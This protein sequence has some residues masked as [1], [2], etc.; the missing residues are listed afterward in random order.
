[1]IDLISRKL[2]TLASTNAASALL[3]TVSKAPNLAQMGAVGD[4]AHPVDDQAAFQSALDVIAN[5]L[6]AAPTG[7]ND[8][9]M[10]QTGA[11]L[12]P[13]IYDAGGLTQNGGSVRLVARVPGTVIIRIPADQ[14]FM[15]VSGKVNAIQV[16][17][18]TFLG[19]KG[20]F[21]FT[22]TSSNVSLLHSFSRCFFYNYTEC[23]I[24]NS[25]I[26]HPYLRVRD[27][28][29]YGAAGCSTMGVSWGGYIDQGV[30]QDCAF[31]QNSYHVKI[32]PQ[33]SSTFTIRHNDFISWGGIAT[34][35]D[36]W[37]V[38]NST[39]SFAT[40]SGFGSLITENKFGNENQNLAAPRILIAKESSTL[41]TD[42]CNTPP[43]T[44]DG[45]Y[46][47]QIL[48]TNNVFSGAAGITAPIIESR[49]SEVRNLEWRGNKLSGS[50]YASII[51]WTNRTT[52]S[53][54]NS[55]SVFEFTTADVA[56]GG[57]A[58]QRFSNISFGQ[59]RDF[60]GLFPG[61]PNNVLVWPI[62]D[63][64]AASL[65]ANGVSSAARSTFGP[66]S[67]AR[68]A[69]LN[70][71]SDYDLVTCTQTGSGN[72]VVMGLGAKAPGSG[73]PIFVELALQ[74]APTRSIAQVKV[75]IFNYA[76][77][78]LA[79]QR[80][81]VLPE[82]V[83][84]L[85]LPV[86]LPAHATPGA[87]QLRIYP[88]SAVTAG[89]ADRFITGDWIVNNGDGRIGRAKAMAAYPLL[90]R[91]QAMLAS[92]AAT[93]PM[94]WAITNPVAGLSYA[95]AQVGSDAYGNFLDLA[96]SGTTTGSGNFL[97]Y[98]DASQTIEAVSGQ[99]WQ[100][101]VPVRLMAGS[102]SAFTT[103]SPIDGSSG[104][105]AAS[106]SSYA[107][108]AYLN[109]IDTAFTPSANYAV[110]GRGDCGGSGFAFHSAVAEIRPYL[111]IMLASGVSVSATLRIY[112]PT[113]RRVV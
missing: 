36:I 11:M 67:R 98:P 45:G 1:M 20:A 33:L 92:A 23:A 74:Q 55:N 28:I 71:G 29:F 22:T 112:T 4:G 111:R 50:V 14:Y 107:G 35:A 63:S 83:G 13:G 110:Y 65:L 43:D 104:Q 48:I 87:W 91:N 106:I 113:I 77:G 88:A 90:P 105:I 76:T 96:L 52:S 30:I 6:S 61:D 56:P 75:E 44:A 12:E 7:A 58:A 64:P 62:S 94:G 38:P 68:V 86:V 102:V 31:L 9:A 97:I 19:G 103:L 78:T 95:V 79:A 3:A 108:G 72:G 80:I 37:V 85:R 66:A 60:C 69:D 2:A 26:D 100:F 51:H 15:T 34:L 57:G 21:K 47:S 27:C 84:H 5:S 93:L 46:L 49:I 73:G 41:G 81:V 53:Y 18:I 54:T 24:S 16:D 59:L 82:R 39:D 40:N 32:G 101:Y 17:G 89:A 42:R 25:S 70:G 8:M 109:Q 10:F 99:C